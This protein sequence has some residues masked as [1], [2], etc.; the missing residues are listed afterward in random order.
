MR[1]EVWHRAAMKPLWLQQ[2]MADM[3]AE[4]REVAT[5]A[6]LDLDDPQVEAV[7]SEP[8][9]FETFNKRLDA[10]LEKRRAKS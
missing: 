8:C 7:L 6:G 1:R 4:A 2:L 5:R 9:D 10:L 3:E